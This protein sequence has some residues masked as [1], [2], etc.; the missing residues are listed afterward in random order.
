MHGCPV[1]GAVRFL[2]FAVLHRSCGTREP[3]VF[4]DH[5]PGVVL[6]RWFELL[7]QTALEGCNCS[8]RSKLMNLWGVAGCRTNLHVIVGWMRSRW[9]TLTVTQKAFVIA[10]A[11]RTGLVCKCLVPPWRP[12][13]SL[14]LAAIRRA[15][16]ATQ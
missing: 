10:S 2:P 7:G 15:E 13:E 14:V 9:K 12:F 11:C 3:V 5:G 8:D 4:P 1:C 6:K 16:I